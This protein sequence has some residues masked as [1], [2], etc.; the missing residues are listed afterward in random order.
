MGIVRGSGTAAIAPPER[1]EH[2]PM[3]VRACPN[4]G[5]PAPHSDR[6]C[7]YCRVELP[8]RPTA[9]GYTIRDIADAL[10]RAGLI[11]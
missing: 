6:V 7:Q 3:S 11:I 1:T 4:C 9:P 8:A 2:L 5:G 10:V